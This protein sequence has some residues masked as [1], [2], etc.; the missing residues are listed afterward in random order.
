MSQAQR[1]LRVVMLAACAILQLSVVDRQFA[2]AAGEVARYAMDE[3]AGTTI[4][5]TSG[6]A[7]TGTLTGAGV[8]R[9]D[10]RFGRALSF[11]GSSGN[12]TV[13]HSASINL[14]SSFTIS[15]WVNATSLTG[16]R[17]ILIKEVTGGCGYWL[18]TAGNQISSG[19]YSA[20][21]CKDHVT[22]S[23]N[24]QT[25]R[26]HHVAAVFDDAAN[27]YRIYLDGSLIST[28]SETGTITPNSQSLVLGQTGYAAGNYERWHGAIDEVRIYNR[29]LAQAEIQADMNTAIGGGGSPPPGDTTAPTVA[30]STPT[31]GTVLAGTVAVSATASDNVAVAGVQFLLDGAPLG[32]EDTASPFSISWNSVS[33]SSGPHVLS[34]RARDTSGNTATSALVTVTVDNQPPAGSIVINGGATATN[35]R[36]ST[37]TLTASDT[38]S[39]VTQMRFSNSGSS[40]SAAEAYATTKAWTLTSGAGTKT[41]YVQ[42]KDALGNWSAAFTD[43]IVLDTTAPTISGVSATDRTSSSVTIGWTTSE[44]ATSRVEYGATTAYGQLSALDAQLVASHSVVLTGLAAETTYNYRVRSRDAAGNE[45]VGTNN[46]VTTLA[47][48]DTTPPS[49]PATLS[50]TSPSPSQIDL[51]WTASTDNVAVTGY[52]VFR[53]GIQIA[54]V[55]GTALQDTS[56]APATTYSYAVS[57]RDAA[58]NVSTAATTV[59][60]TLPANSG[61]GGVF[62]NEIIVTGLTLPTCMTFLPDGRMLI[63]ELVGS[64]WILRPGATQVDPVPFLD[65]AVGS[66]GERGINDIVLDPDFATNGHYYVFY[67]PASPN[68]NRVSRFTANGSTTDLATEV[69]VYQDDIDAENEHHGG[70]L[71]FGIDGKLYITTGDHFRPLDAQS[72]TSYHGKILRINKDGTIPADNPFHDGAGPNKDAIWAL[73]LRNPYRASIDPVTGRYYIGDVGGNDALRSIEKV[74]LGA[75]GANYSWPICEFQACTGPGYTAPIHWYGHDGRDAAITG[76]FVYRGNQFPSEYV[77][78]YFFADYTQNWIRRLTFDVDGTVAAVHDF[79]PPDGSKD[80]PYGDIVYLREGPDGALYYVDIGYDEP[81]GIFGI[82]KIRRIRFVGSS[83]QP[84]VAVATATPSE[85]PTP[86][87]VTF[88]STGSGDPEGQPLSYLWTF[89]DGGTSIESNP[90]HEYV[91]AG[92]YTARLTVS[93][94]VNSTLAPPFTIRAGNRPVVAVSAPQ[95]GSGFRAG[96]VITFSGDASDVE[97]GALPASAFTW[98]IDFHHAT[99]V[100]PGLPTSGSKTG[101]F[102]VPT[103][104]H[105][106]DETTSYEIRLTVTDST[107][108]QSSRSV[109]VYPITVSLHFDTAPSGLIVSVDGI[110]RTTPFTQ[111]ALVS[112][113]HTVDAPN[114]TQGS[115]SY[116][117][118]SWSDGGAQQHTLVVPGAAQ[119]YVATYSVTSNP[120][121]PGLVAAYGMNEG[122]GTVLRDMTGVNDGAVSGLSWTQGKY[123]TGLSFSGTVGNVTIPA[124]PTIN[125]TSSF[126][127]SAWINPAS[128]TGYRTVLIKEVTGGC[129]YWLQTAGNQISSG[130][131][132]G[133]FCRDHATTSVNLQAGTWY[134][135]AAVFDDT[136][137]TYKIYLDGTLVSSHTETAT[138]APNTENLVLGQTAYAAGGY[139]RWHGSIDE[140]R[141]YDRALSPSEI[142]ADMATPL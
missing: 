7:N 46:T 10:G 19:F 114:Q 106:F 35:S 76:G 135:V 116:T 118:A 122:S 107:G 68:R 8:T 128:L 141:I 109:F 64:V 92:Q 70:S 80:G 83:N 69:V 103:T 48:P 124:S 41:V 31:A 13:P 78:S 1:A 87:T 75:R 25:G 66:G 72:L 54:T 134:H 105:T 58:G 2:Y 53:D 49:R 130:F 40:Y 27:A 98:T 33:A 42:F 132:D 63:G 3:T 50:A 108:L 125:L 52:Q 28:H 56:L 94:G 85:G 29:A 93:D 6:N 81:A 24:L 74:N 5:D 32:A 18:Q 82:G 119:S 57:A 84:P 34:A 137:N 138:I 17:T 86:L 99:H 51:A 14:T 43:T 37:L 47:G 136:A 97:D 60:T 45:R 111:S 100:H 117:F 55:S 126:T 16:Y 139:E 12:V 36:S 127:I 71:N 38:A 110:P 65:L 26:W 4:T 123:G 22:A 131:S 115:S 129:G 62:Q 101:T 95:D 9:I 61:G 23:A 15:A 73:G 89:G 20:G 91:Q 90:V 120:L 113:A 133:M 30:L 79:E 112:F 21:I 77:G 140:L 67:T 88:S 96:D 59:A 142:Q 44:P 102:Q 11:D 104:G 121:P 39:A